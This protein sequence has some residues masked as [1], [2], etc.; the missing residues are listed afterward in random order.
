M[1]ARPLRPQT[2]APQREL[3]G[4]RRAV[5][6]ARNELLGSLRAL[7]EPLGEVCA[8]FYEQRVRR[9]SPKPL[10]GE[11][12]PWMLGDLLGAAPSTTLRLTAAWLPLYLHVLAI[13]DWLDD[14]VDVDRQT[15]PIVSSVFAE[16]AFQTYLAIFGSDSRFW[17]RFERFFLRTGAAGTREMVFARNRIPSITPDDLLAAGEKI[18][19]IKICLLSL[20]LATG[21]E[22]KDAHL[23]A[24]DDFAIGVQLLDD[25][26]DW[27]QDLAVGNFTPLLAMA[28]ADT[29]ERRGIDSPQEVLARLVATGALGRCLDEGADR[30]ERAAAMASQG[31][32]SRGARF[33]AATVTAMRSVRRESDAVL[34]ILEE[35]DA[36]ADNADVGERLRQDP[37]LARALLSLQHSIRIV[38]QSS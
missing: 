36:S 29:D 37:R 8:E 14:E 30:L 35:D 1:F 34:Q 38:A 23:A 12:L 13:D 27:E 26:G 31:T 11:Y 15:L 6:R 21:Q 20:V 9:A 32:R 10:L 25:I 5:L 33:L 22:L 18:D 17:P 19:L 2:D 7:P 28:F 16:R 3:L 24:L 4:Y